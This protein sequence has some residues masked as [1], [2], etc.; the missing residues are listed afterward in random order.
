VHNNFVITLD[1]TFPHS[2]PEGALINKLNLTLYGRG[3]H[4]NIYVA[5]LFLNYGSNVVH[6]AELIQV[7]KI[8]SFIYRRDLIVLQT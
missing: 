5:L 3:D 1:R 4:W 6:D 8:T 2:Q 7:N